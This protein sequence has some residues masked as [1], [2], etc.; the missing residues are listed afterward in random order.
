MARLL[1]YDRNFGDRARGLVQ[2]IILVKAGNVRSKTSATQLE[3]RLSAFD[4]IG[5]L[6]HRVEI[7]QY[8]SAP[9]LMMCAARRT[10]VVYVTPGLNRRPRRSALHFRT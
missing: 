9:A 10:S 2:I 4:R 7:V 5:G 1:P 6:P 8:E 3:R